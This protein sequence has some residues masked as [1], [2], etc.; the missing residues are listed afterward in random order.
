MSTE[1]RGP[2]TARWSGHPSLMLVQSFL[3]LIFPQKKKK[4]K[5]K[6]SLWR[7]NS[8]EEMFQ[9]FSMN[10]FISSRLGSESRRYGIRSPSRS[11]P[12]AQISNAASALRANLDEPSFQRRDFDRDRAAGQSRG[13]RHRADGARIDSDRPRL[14]PFCT[15]RCPLCPRATARASGEKAANSIFRLRAASMVQELQTWRRGRSSKETVARGLR[16]RANISQCAV[17]GNAWSPELAAGSVRSKQRRTDRH[18]LTCLYVM[19]VAF[20]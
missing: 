2:L 12:H 18:S 3:P 6:L 7:A 8:V 5:E 17:P 9:C 11:A 1:V 10:K 13:P 19:V 14:D 16:N 4:K 15:G 20:I